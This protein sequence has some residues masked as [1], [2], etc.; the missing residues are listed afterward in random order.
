VKRASL[1]LLAFF[2]VALALGESSSLYGLEGLA[3]SERV[4][5]PGTHGFSD[6][7]FDFIFA[8]G[9]ALVQPSI[10]RTTASDHWP[11]M[12]DFRLH[13]VFLALS[14]LSR[15]LLPKATVF[16]NERTNCPA[17]DVFYK[18]F[19]LQSQC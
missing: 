4:T 11:V 19:P 10:T 1:A 6:A 9:L 2:V 15:F 5:H 18:L 13:R 8:K 14:P 16:V 12:R 7:T 3:L 17:A